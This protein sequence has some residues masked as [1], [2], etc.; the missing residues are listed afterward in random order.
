MNINELDTIR[1]DLTELCHEL[2]GEDYDKRMK[3]FVE[4]C[5]L[6]NDLIQQGVD[7]SNFI[8]KCKEH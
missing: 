7:F 4:F 1:Y 6:R 2:V 5:D 8:L 3:A